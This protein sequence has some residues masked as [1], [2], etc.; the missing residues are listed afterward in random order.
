MN[1]RTK[2]AV[3]IALTGL[4]LTGAVFGV[5]VVVTELPA[6]LIAS[7]GV[8]VAGSAY[9]RLKKRGTCCDEAPDCEC[10]E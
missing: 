9:K 8:V 6:I 2:D 5:A 4:G 10:D 7:A 1:D 3:D